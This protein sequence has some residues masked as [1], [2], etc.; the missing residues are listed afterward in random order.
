MRPTRVLRTAIGKWRGT[1]H[2]MRVFCSASRTRSRLVYEALG[3]SNLMCDRSLYINLGYWE[4]ARDLDQACEDLAEQLGIAAGLAPEDFVL[5]AGCGF[6]D[7]DIFWI[8]RFGPREITAINITPS[9]IEVARSRS[10][11]PD[12]IHFVSG[13]A[14]T[15]TFP[16]NSFDKVLALESAFH[17]VSRETFLRQ[18]FRV[19]RSGGM[20]AAADLIRKDSAARRS[21]PRRLGVQLGTRAWQIPIQN[22]YGAARYRDI[23]RKCG[24]EEINMH[25][26]SQHVFEPFT[27]FLR[28]RLNEP[29]FRERFHPMVLAA[30]KL[31]IDLGFL[32]ELDYVLVSARKP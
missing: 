22:L 31:Q 9:Q 6:G 7:Q 29:P 18:A 23:L 10:P 21:F 27:A 8:K 32:R 5:D 25:C 26:I 17:F 4:R 15:L 19:L 20:L 3:D 24:Y 11:W 28:P 14:T 1:S 30:A 13:D 2:L 16:S 12:R